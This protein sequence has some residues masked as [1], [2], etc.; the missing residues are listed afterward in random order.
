ML[1]IFYFA[2]IYYLFAYRFYSAK[3]ANKNIQ[4]QE[5]KIMKISL[6]FLLA[7][8]TMLSLS[9]LVH[10]ALGEPFSVL[11]Q[12]CLGSSKEPTLFS[13]IVI[14]IGVNGF[15]IISLILS[16]L[17]VF[18]V[19]KN[20]SVT[21]KPHHQRTSGLSKSSYTIPVRALVLSALS[22]IP[23]FIITFLIRTKAVPL[24]TGIIMANVLSLVTSIIRCPL[25]IR[26]TFTAKTE[27]DAANRAM[28]QERE[29][30]FARR[31]REEREMEKANRLE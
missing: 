6:A 2:M 10:V 9:L 22:I 18:Y 26:L 8:M 4:T 7:T 14:F 27:K 25:A 13:K 29:R 30:E 21:I 23:G 24:D 5:R 28:R 15:P 31:A 20:V 3:R 11:V 12:Q 16:I 17:I 1:F 19:K